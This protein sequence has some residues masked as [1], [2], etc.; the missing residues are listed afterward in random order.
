MT[1]LEAKRFVKGFNDN[2]SM[3]FLPDK[4]ASAKLVGNE[5]VINIGRRDSA[6]DLNWKH[7][8]GGTFLAS[9]WKITG[10]E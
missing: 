2:F 4:F 6:F 1:L 5:I 3:P 9:G 10:K 7:V 8:G